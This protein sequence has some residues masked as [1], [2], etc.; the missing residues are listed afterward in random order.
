M[1]AP[2]T[3][4]QP[5]A[6]TGLIKTGQLIRRMQKYALGV[7]NMTQTEL[8]AAKALLALA[9]AQPA[10]RAEPAGAPAETYEEMLDRLDK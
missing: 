3:R 10:K 1:T 2:K 9:T 4:P 8:R 5:E 7:E 6:L